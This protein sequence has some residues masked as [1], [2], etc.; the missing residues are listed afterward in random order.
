MFELKQTK[1]WRNKA[2]NRI[3]VSQKLTIFFL[4]AHND[5]FTCKDGNFK[6]YFTG[7]WMAIRWRKKGFSS[8][9]NFS[10]SCE[11][12]SLLGLRHSSLA[13]IKM[14]HSLRFYSQ[15][16][17]FPFPNCYRRLF[18]RSSSKRN[19]VFHDL[20]GETDENFTLAIC[21]SLILHSVIWS[22]KMLKI[23]FMS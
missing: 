22:S 19:K 18:F 20:S 9:W 6:T 7:G 5:R 11:H 8:R 16:S 23:L 3:C 1:C 15:S 4:L 14:S 12:G 2:V 17:K 13:E 21:D 10:F